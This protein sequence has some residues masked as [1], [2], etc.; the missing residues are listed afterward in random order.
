MFDYESMVA[1]Q[2]KWMLYLLAIMVLGAGFLPHPR[3]FNGLILGAVVS[4]YNLWLLQHKT[5]YLANAVASNSKIRGGLGTFSRLAAVMLAV[6]IAIRFEEHFHII[7]L[8]V[9]IVSSYAV[10]GLDL[11]LRMFSY[12]KKHKEN[13]DK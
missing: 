9:G 5:T 2:R 1:R 8:V 4:F 7:A 11:T 13:K 3:I 10:L 12:K 6:L